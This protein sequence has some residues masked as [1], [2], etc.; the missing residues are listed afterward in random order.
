[1]LNENIFGTGFLARPLAHGSR[2][3]GIYPHWGNH[4]LQ[5]LEQ[6]HHLLHQP[7]ETR[8]LC[9]GTLQSI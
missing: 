8:R 2:L 1:M 6:C 7:E 4:L 3:K 9:L 5:Y